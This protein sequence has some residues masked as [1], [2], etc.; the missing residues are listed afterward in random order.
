MKKLKDSQALW[1]LDEAV[2]GRKLYGGWVSGGDYTALDIQLIPCASRYVAFDG[3]VSEDDGSC[4]WDMDA[5]IE[6]LG[7]AISTLVLSNNS[8][9]NP[10]EFGEERI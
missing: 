4:I 9:F 6:Y 1:C 3:T 7:S 8:V 5:T 10:N 2:I